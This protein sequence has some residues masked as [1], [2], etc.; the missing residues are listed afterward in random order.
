MLNLSM[1]RIMSSA[2]HKEIVRFAEV[3]HIA[4]RKRRV[5]ALQ[6]LETIEALIQNMERL[7]KIVDQV[8]KEHPD[9]E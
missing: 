3:T 4:L 1:N 6:N 8:I 5:E 2:E 7:K 9:G